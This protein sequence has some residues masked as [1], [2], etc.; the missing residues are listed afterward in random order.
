MSTIW[1]VNSASAATVL[2]SVITR[3]P[4]AFQLGTDLGR[5]CASHA[6]RRRLEDVSGR[7]LKT[8]GIM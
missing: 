7:I 3:Y 6:C 1:N 8:S 2:T 4:R 5:R